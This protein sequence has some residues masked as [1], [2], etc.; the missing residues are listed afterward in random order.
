MPCQQYEVY[1]GEAS[2]DKGRRFKSQADIQVWVDEIVNQSWWPERHPKVI[3][4]EVPTVNRRGTSGSVGD[5]FEDGCGVIEMAEV[6]WCELYVLHEMSHVC[7]DA[8]GSHAHDPMFCRMYLE[9]VYRIMGTDTW[10]QLRQ[11]LLNHGVIIDERM[12]EDV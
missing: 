12:E 3:T 6:H 5:W 11:S 8:E 4:I 9:L 1:A 10:M 2:V 7:A